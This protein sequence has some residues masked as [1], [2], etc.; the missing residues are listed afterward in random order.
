MRRLLVL[1]LLLV[2]A[3]ARAT[4]LRADPCF[5]DR[6]LRTGTAPGGLYRTVAPFEHFGVDRTQVFPHTCSLAEL[7]GPA[8]ALLERASPDTFQTPYTAVTRER[9]Q[10]Y[11][12]GYGSD[13]ATEGGFVAGVDPGT[14]RRRWETRILDPAPA[15]Q[16]SYPGVM[17]VHGNGSVYAVYG[18]VLVRLDADTGEVLA[19]TTLPEDPDGSGAAYNGMVVMPDGRIV[20]KKIERGPCPTQVPVPGVNAAPGALAGLTCANLNALPSLMVV[21]DPA[22]LRVL[23]TVVPP[24]PVTGRITTARVDGADYVFAAGRDSLFRFRYAGGALTLD[25]D[26]GPVT[27]RTG[28]QQPGTGP[29][30]LG[31]FLVVQTNFLPSREPMTITAVDLRD[32]RRVF[33]ARPFGAPSLQ[34]S[35]AALDTATMTVVSHDFTAGQMAALHLDPQR[36]FEVRWQRPLASLAFS[37]LAGPARDREIVIP[38][39]RGAAETVVWLDE[40]TGEERVRSSTLSRAPAPGNIVTPGFGGRFYYTSGQGV[41]TELRPDPSGRDA[42]PPRLRVRAT[43]R[44]VRIRLDEPARVTIRAGGRV[45]RRSLPAGRTRVPFRTRARRVRVL[46][47][48]AAGNPRAARTRVAAPS[49]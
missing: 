45:R 25:E 48:D 11:V 22:D 16:W 21:V 18:N 6:E 41:L 27:Y 13:A 10:L 46:A 7:A 38:D 17:L 31:G 23:E 44:A 24:E 39:L 43:R 49:R 35:K 37:A 20:A 8:P 32:D 15:G 47:R 12:Y 1:A 29:G 28:D 36:G 3:P 42:T 26:W 19:R 40:R 5:R 2:P 30:V 9:D 34:V 4:D 33:T 14:L